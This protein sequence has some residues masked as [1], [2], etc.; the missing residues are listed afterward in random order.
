[1]HPAKFLV[2]LALAATPLTPATAIAE[3]S[4]LRIGLQ[5]DPDILD[6]AQGVSF[7]GRE[8]FAA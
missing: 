6:P 5:E 8:V 1:M 4:T 7:V 2:A 3:P